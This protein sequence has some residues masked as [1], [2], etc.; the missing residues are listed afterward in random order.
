MR[1]F[2]TEMLSEVNANVELLSTTYKGNTALKVVFE[3][4][5]IPENKFDLP[6][7]TPPFK[8]DSAPIGMTP[9]TL[10]GELRRFYVFTKMRPLAK[11]RKESLFVQLLEG[12]HPTEAAIVIAIK[13]QKLSD[14]YPN[15]TADVAFK[16][17]F[18]PEQVKQDEESK[19]KKS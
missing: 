1:K 8:H 16:Y 14:L 2:L 11:I 4:S 19:A 6:E 13:D 7:G 5:F 12:I 9:A 15:I 17:G 10:L 18:I 3:H